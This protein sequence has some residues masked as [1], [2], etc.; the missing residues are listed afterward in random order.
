MEKVGLINTFLHIRGIGEKRERALWRR[1]IR[2]WHDVIKPGAD[3]RWLGKREAVVK[4]AA[5]VSLEALEEGDAAF[6]AQRL[7]PWERLRVLSEFEDRTA[8]LDIETDPYRITVIGILYQGLYR[9]FMAGGDLADFYDLMREIKVVV[10]YNGSTFDIPILNRALFD[11]SYRQ[12]P[13]SPDLFA[14]PR[15][16][17]LPGTGHIDLMSVCHRLGLRGGLKA[18]EERLGIVRPASVRG[19]DGFDA[20]RLWH[21]W[22]AG[23]DTSLELLLEYNRQDVVNLQR[24]VRLLL[25]GKLPAKVNPSMDPCNSAGS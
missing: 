11:F 12:R 3:L 23:D 22:K 10:T 17:H 13:A 25:E 5:E 9:A 7:P 16:V 18:T 6:F 20:V 21:N 1:G 24:I 2:R 15:G 8:Y 4:Q 14:P 19:M